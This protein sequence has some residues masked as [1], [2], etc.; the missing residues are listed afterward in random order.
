M[1]F[2]TTHHHDEEAKEVTIHVHA[3]GKKHQ[4]HDKATR[5]HHDSKKMDSEKEGCCNDGVIRFQSLD[6]NLSQNAN[7]TIIVPVFATVLINFFGLNIFKQ[8]KVSND[9]YI[10]RFFHPPPPDIRLLIRSFQI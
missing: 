5:H 4:H 3:D 9:K 10:A 6:K 1:G 8:E 7:S 2:N